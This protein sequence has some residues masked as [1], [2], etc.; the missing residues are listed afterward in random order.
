MKKWEYKTVSVFRGESCYTDEDTN[1]PVTFA[2][3]G[4]AG[5]ELCASVSWNDQVIFYHFKRE[6]E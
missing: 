3:L 2:E 6:A 5:W 4:G 1:S